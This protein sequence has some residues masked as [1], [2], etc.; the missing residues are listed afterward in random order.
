MNA[1]AI[2]GMTALVAA[3][4]AILT[5]AVLRFFEAARGTRHVLGDRDRETAWIAAAMED[6]VARLKTQ[7]QAMAARVAA[8]ERLSNAMV[9][10][11]TSGL[12]VV[13]LD[14]RVPMAN[15][16][17]RRLLG[18]PDPVADGVPYRDLLAHVAPLAAAIGECLESGHAIVRRAL[19]LER[20]GQ[21]MFLGVTV[22]P[23]YGEGG[24][25]AG[26]ICLFTDLTAVRELEERIRL[27]ESLARVGELT[28]GLAHEFR[29]G[30]AT[31]HGYSRLIDLDSLPE[32]YRPYVQAIRDET[33]A[34]G[35]VVTNFLAFARPTTLTLT[36]VDLRAIAARAAEDA[37]AE[38]RTRRGTIEVRGTFPTIDGDE[39]LLRQAF[40]NLLRNAV[41]SCEAAQIA[42]Q[43]VVESMLEPDQ[44]TARI[45][46]TDNGAGIDPADRERIFRPFFTT[47]GT[48]TGLGLAIVQKIIVSHNGRVSAGQAPG[49]GAR[50]QIL[51]PVVQ[52]DGR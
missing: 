3:L 50:I 26:A 32:S 36:P 37:Q 21:P 44:R 28:A 30:L 15:P 2:F 22:S 23:L 43:I 48:G 33:E 4:A 25:P 1:Y 38:G 35:E 6:A 45:T 42:P 10:S 27:K 14:G 13:D 5:F 52:Q 19:D 31:I 46:V 16:A 18:L 39:V 20:N 40:A 34:L 8:S 29:N 51:V 9:A 41:E 47:K 7:E 49:G 12:L 24:A 17:G 11:L